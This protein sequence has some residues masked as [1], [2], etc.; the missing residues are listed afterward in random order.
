MNLFPEKKPNQKSFE[1]AI[2]TV[3]VFMRS[4]PHLKEWQAQDNLSIALLFLAW[5]I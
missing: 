3:L 2:T 5:C 4:Q 1:V